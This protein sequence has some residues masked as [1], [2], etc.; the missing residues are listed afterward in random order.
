LSFCS[1]FSCLCS[2]IPE[3]NSSDNKQISKVDK[4]KSLY[5]HGE[6]KNFWSGAKATSEVGD[7]ICPVNHT[8]T[9]GIF[10]PPMTE[11]RNKDEEGQIEA[12]DT[13][14]SHSLALCDVVPS[15]RTKIKCKARRMQVITDKLKISKIIPSGRLSKSHRES[16][17]YL[18]SVSS[19]SFYLARYRLVKMQD[20]VELQAPCN[21]IR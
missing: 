2:L 18:C 14:Q 9:P 21:F 10:E 8:R 15:P 11:R 4:K 16:A 1:F 7:A 19:R 12:P 5:G 6:K 3:H 20:M 17:R 13:R